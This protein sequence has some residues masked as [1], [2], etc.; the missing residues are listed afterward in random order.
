MANP[1]AE[2]LLCRS[3]RHEYTQ[4]ILLTGLLLDEGGSN[5]EQGQAFKTSSSA[6][7]LVGKLIWDCF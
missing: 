4:L 5:K 1:S 2:V 6:G 7:M 3:K